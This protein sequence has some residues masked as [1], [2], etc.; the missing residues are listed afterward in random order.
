MN[1]FSFP[2]LFVCVY[3]V[4]IFISTVYFVFIFVQLL[5]FFWFHCITMSCHYTAIY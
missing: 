2:G 3:F 5:L 1:F 4:I